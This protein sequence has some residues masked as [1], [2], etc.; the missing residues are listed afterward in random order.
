[1][2]DDG[3]EL[4]VPIKFKVRSIEGFSAH[5]SRNQLLAFVAN[6]NPKPKKIIINHGEVSRALDL[7]SSL[8]KM[9]K[10]ET[11]VPKNLEVIRLR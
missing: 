10:I 7:A 5:S 4:T 3:K 2:Q 1:M 9:E 8:Y 11:V 6:I